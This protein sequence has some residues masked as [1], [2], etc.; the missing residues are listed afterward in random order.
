MLRVNLA[1]TFLLASKPSQ[2]DQQRQCTEAKPGVQGEA[3]SDIQCL[4]DWTEGCDASGSQA[5]PDQVL[6]SLR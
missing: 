6:R 4:N 5:T 1:D 2:R 3:P